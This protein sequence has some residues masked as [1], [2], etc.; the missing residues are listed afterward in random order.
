MAENVFNKMA[1]RYDNEERVELANTI[2]RGIG[3]YLPQSAEKHCWIMVQAQDWL[4]TV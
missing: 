3:Q 2:A 4:I 1:Q